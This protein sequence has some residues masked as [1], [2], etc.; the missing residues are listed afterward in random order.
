MEQQRPSGINLR[1]R[2]LF[3][4]DTRARVRTH[5][6]FDLWAEPFREEPHRFIESPQPKD[7]V[8]RIVTARGVGF[9]INRDF[10]DSQS[11]YL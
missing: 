9:D 3:G 11:P 5:L 10:V 2:K 1:S 6:I 4:D 8:Y 7:C